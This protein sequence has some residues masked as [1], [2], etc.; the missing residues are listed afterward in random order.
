MSPDAMYTRR[1]A[2]AL[3]GGLSALGA[4]G[5]FGCSG[6]SE[7][8]TDP[9][10]KTGFG[11]DTLVKDYPVHLKLYADTNIMWRFDH[12][13]DLYGDEA[14]GEKNHL[15]HYITRYRSLSDRGDVSIEVEYLDPFELMEMAQHGFNDGDGVL[16]LSDIVAAGCASGALEGGDSRLHVRDM[17][18]NFVDQCCVVR[19]AGSGVELPPAPTVDGQDSSDGDY[20]KFRQ[21]ADFDGRIALA[22]SARSVESIM[23][24]DMMKSAHLYRV[25]SASGAVA[26]AEGLQEKIIIYP[27]QEDAMK[28]VAKGDCQIGFA[29][30]SALERRFLQVEK[31]YQPG[32]AGSQ[33]S[34]AACTIAGSSEPAVMRDF[35]EFV[36]KL[37]D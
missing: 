11:W 17:T 31:L 13:A 32:E 8:E 1:Q 9:H 34:N 28:A 36:I 21:L 26:Y 12:Q 30:E 20:T 22:D 2:L 16:T 19:A 6:G 18:Y 5:A 35:F 29:L 14:W 37:S 25:D 4:L 7:E 33:I 24:L 27:S 10:A 15:E 23:A 3:I